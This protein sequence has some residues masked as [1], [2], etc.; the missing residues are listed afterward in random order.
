MAH[1]IN[2]AEIAGIDGFNPHY[3]YEHPLKF[4]TLLNR[5]VKE[6]YKSKDG[7]K[8]KSFLRSAV[9]SVN[10]HMLLNKLEVGRD[11]DGEKNNPVAFKH[12]FEKLARNVPHLD[13]KDGKIE[14]KKDSPPHLVNTLYEQLWLKANERVGAVPRT[15]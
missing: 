7:E 4:H 5:Y 10:H 14:Y 1:G 6:N 3:Q 8:Y 12:E 15:S 11:E 13:V 2:L 9:K